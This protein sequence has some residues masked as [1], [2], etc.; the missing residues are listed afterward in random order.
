MDRVVPFHPDAVLGARAAHLWYA[1][2]NER[3][4]AAFIE[5]LDVA[6]RAIA[7]ALLSWSQDLHGT[8]SCLMRRFPFLVVN[9]VRDHVVLVVAVA[10]GRRRP[11]YWRE[12]PRAR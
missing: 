10:H 11:G 4:T 12:R 2:R 8:R 9:T 3:S 6:L 1:E 5:S 7:Q